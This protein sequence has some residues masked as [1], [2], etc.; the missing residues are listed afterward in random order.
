MFVDLDWPLN[1]SSLL[2]ASAELLVDNSVTTSELHYTVIGRSERRTLWYDA[3]LTA[4]YSFK[5]RS[6]QQHNTMNTYP[7]LSK[8]VTFLTFLFFFYSS[9]LYFVPLLFQLQF[10][11]LYFIVLFMFFLFNLQ[12]LRFKLQLIRLQYTQNTKLLWNIIETVFALTSRPK[13]L[14]AV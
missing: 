14:C 1:A 13:R 12:L 9:F 4:C 11:V 7:R 10:F 6:N 8:S 2:S 5:S 3:D